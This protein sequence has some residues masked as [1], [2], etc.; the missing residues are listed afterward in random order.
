META[1]QRSSFLAPLI[2]V[3]IALA[4]VIGSFFAPVATHA[5]NPTASHW[6]A[7]ASIAVTV[8][9]VGAA[10]I[11]LSGLKYFKSEMRA[12]YR[13]LAFSMLAFSLVF[14]Q[15]SI[16]GIFDLWSSAWAASGSGLLPFV[17]TMA[18]IH[19]AVRKFARLLKVASIFSK[20]WFVVLVSLAVG[21]GMGIFAHY[22]VKY[23]IDGTDLYIGTCSGVAVY[24][25]CTA[26]LMFK[27]L[28]A[29]GSS[30]QRAMRWIAISLSALAIAA[31]HEAINTL[32]FNNG[33]T[34]TDYGYYLI[35]W[36]ING[37][38]LLFASH[39]FRALTV[40]TPVVEA[41]A[42]PADPTDHDYIDSIVMVAGLA[43]RRE[44]VDPI[45][46]D[47]RGVT[48][49]LK[50]GTTMADADKQRLVQTYERLENYLL[51]KDPARTYTGDEVLSQ[52][53]PAFR[54]L[55]ENNDKT[56]A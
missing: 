17:I 53:T 7:A 14:I 15:L 29:I 43:S 39:E 42:A 33:S 45:L 55:V 22:F 9:Y 47:L 56:D 16:W 34:Y 37:F 51:Q 8:M 32:W 28:P 1:K 30:Y 38:I 41:P 31:W 27:I 11:Y 54:K 12:A 24:I 10:V 35:P 5:V 4:A 20:V 2:V 26:L 18:F 40:L 48:A 50:P 46:D 36:V 13:S 23:D 25:T 6:R 49:S 19:I 52:T 3:A 21:I 44:D